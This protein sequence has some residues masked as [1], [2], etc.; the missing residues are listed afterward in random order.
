MATTKKKC[1]QSNRWD[2][3]RKAKKTKSIDFK[4]IVWPKASYKSLEFDGYFC[5][6][7][8]QRSKCEPLLYVKYE[9]TRDFLVICLYVDDLIYMGTNIKMVE[10]FKKAMMKEFEMTDLGL[11]KYFLGFQV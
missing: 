1:M 2:T 5:Q 6:N 4:D 7:G 11:V 8:F 10:D 9:G 3:L